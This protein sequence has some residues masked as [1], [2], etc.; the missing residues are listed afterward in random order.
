MG[1]G[2]YFHEDMMKIRLFEWSDSVKTLKK[3]NLYY[4]TQ[5]KERD[6]KEVNGEFLKDEDVL[7]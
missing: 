3:T 5:F 7:L 2:R 1:K 6:F 4:K